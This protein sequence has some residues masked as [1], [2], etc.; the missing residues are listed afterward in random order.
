M[1]YN[2]FT[3]KV[4]LIKYKRFKD[5]LYVPTKIPGRA[6]LIS[7]LYFVQ[8]Q[9]FVKPMAILSYSDYGTIEIAAMDLRLL[10]QFKTTPAFSSLID[11][12]RC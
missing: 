1:C 12:A 8:S 7:P 2:V 6:T 11:K 10:R 3:I 5:G 9:F 4:N